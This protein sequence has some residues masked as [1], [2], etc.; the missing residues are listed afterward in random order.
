MPA[1]QHQVEHDARRPDVD[2][3]AVA[4]AALVVHLGRSVLEET[5]HIGHGVFAWVVSARDVEVDEDDAPVISLDE[6][7][8]W[9]DVAVDNDWLTPMQVC[10]CFQYLAK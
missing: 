1:R 9:L 10:D 5:C 4:V 8:V 7:V 6:Q 3:L 2:L